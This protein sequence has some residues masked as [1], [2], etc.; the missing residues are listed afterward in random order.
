[1]TNPY[2]VSFLTFQRVVREVSVA[3]G[4]KYSCQDTGPECTDWVQEE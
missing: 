2:H 1:M 3:Q 4:L